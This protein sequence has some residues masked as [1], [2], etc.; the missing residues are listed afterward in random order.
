V[1]SALFRF[2]GCVSPNQVSELGVCCP[3][4]V[5]RVR[6]NSRDI[7]QGWGFAWDA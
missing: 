6:L 3:V 2:L 1:S 7:G 5:G 4:H